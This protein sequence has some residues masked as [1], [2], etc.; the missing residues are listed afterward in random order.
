M[1]RYLFSARF[2]GAVVVSS[3]CDSLPRKNAYNN[4]NEVRYGLH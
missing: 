3:D 1:L 4:L 2:H